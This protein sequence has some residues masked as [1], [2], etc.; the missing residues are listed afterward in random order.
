MRDITICSRPSPTPASTILRL[1]ITAWVWATIPSGNTPG[2]SGVSGICPV[3]K[4]KPSVSTAWLNGAT[5]LGPPA[6]MWNFNG[7]LGWSRLRDIFK[8]ALAQNGVHAPIAVH[9]L[10][11]AKIHRRRHQR[12]RLVLAQPF[13][14]HQEAAHLA[15]RVLHRKIERRCRVDL[16]LSLGAELGEI[17]GVA[18]PGQHPVGLGLD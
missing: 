18:E 1:A 11:D 4:T 13:D 17:V 10:G 7:C 8:Q 5:G 3:T 16:A 6:I 15:E 9:H 14:V 2:A 12:D